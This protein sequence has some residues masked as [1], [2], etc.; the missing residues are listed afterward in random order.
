[1]HKNPPPCRTIKIVTF[2]GIRSPIFWKSFQKKLDD[3]KQGK[4][5][6]PTI[7]E[8]LLYAGHTGVSTNGGTT[9]YGFNPDGEGVPVW[10]LMDRL[11]Y[12]DRFHGVVRDDTDIFVRS[13]PSRGLMP[14][15]FDIVLPEP[16]FELFESNLD[17]E[18]WKS[19]YYYG[20]PNG[21]GDCN[22]TTWLERLG[23]PL[24]SGRMNEFAGLLAIYPNPRRRFGRCV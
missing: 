16:K 21:D 20:F 14:L 6:G 8:C 9:I 13:A 11:K 1:M 12:G 22:C 18:R 23:L 15:W 5:T 3:E 17:D 4:G 10:L 7:E 2:R 24:L 19:Q